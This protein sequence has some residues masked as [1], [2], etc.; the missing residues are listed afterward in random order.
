MDPRLMAMSV[1]NKKPAAGPAAQPLTARSQ[2]VQPAAQNTSALPASL[3][4]LLPQKPQNTGPLLPLPLNPTA[5]SQAQPSVPSQPQAHS[6]V[7]HHTGGGRP[8]G[9]GAPMSM[10]P[11][12]VPMMAS[13]LAQ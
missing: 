10:A 9:L 3:S 2:A 11:A 6:A 13:A 7:Q 8:V 4:M 12:P 1:V 5:G